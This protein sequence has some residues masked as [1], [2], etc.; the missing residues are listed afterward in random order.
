MDT[1][2]I[3]IKESYNRFQVFLHRRVGLII[4]IK[5]ITFDFLRKYD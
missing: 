3:K 4:L 5:S 2:L 1:T